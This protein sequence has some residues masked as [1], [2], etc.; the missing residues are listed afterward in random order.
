M[1]NRGQRKRRK[2][3]RSWHDVIQ[4]SLMAPRLF[5][6]ELPLEKLSAGACKRAAASG[7]ATT[8]PGRPT[9]RTTARERGFPA[10]AYV[11]LSFSF[12]ASTA[13]DGPC[14]FV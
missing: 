2:G 10:P 12:L 11:A 8:A 1:D 6:T 5:T 4:V 3:R 7:A 14:L 13:P 9:A